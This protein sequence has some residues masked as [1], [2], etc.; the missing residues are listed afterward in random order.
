MWAREQSVSYLKQYIRAKKETPWVVNMCPIIEERAKC[1]LQFLG[2]MS[3]D[4]YGQRSAC[5]YYQ[6]KVKE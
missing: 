6:Q 4:W 3:G 5:Y 2:G 1:S